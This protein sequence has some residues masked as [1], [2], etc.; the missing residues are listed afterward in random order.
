[1][2]IQ[3][4]DYVFDEPI[5]F[6][7]W[8]PPKQP[9]IYAVLVHDPKVKPKP[10]TVLFFGESDN[11]SDQAFFRSHIKYSCWTKQAGAEKNLFITQLKMPDVDGI[12]RKKI[13]N[14]LIQKYQPVCN[15]V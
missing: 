7:K 14:A 11:L 8:Q 13:L 12:Q 1:M 3:F 2:S 10:Y 15:E 6:G 9:C 4:G 5:P